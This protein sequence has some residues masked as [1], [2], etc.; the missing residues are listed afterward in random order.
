[1]SGDLS[2]IKNQVKSYKQEGLIMRYQ[3]IR[4]GLIWVSTLITGF[5]LFSCSSKDSNTLKRGKT[6][7][8]NPITTTIPTARQL[9]YKTGTNKVETFK[10]VR[11]AFS[12]DVVNRSKSHLMLAFNLNP[13]VWITPSIVRLSP[14]ARQNVILNFRSVNKS[15]LFS[16]A[17]AVSSSLFT[18]HSYRY[19]AYSD[20]E[21]VMCVPVDT[22]LYSA[23][24]ARTAS[25]LADS[26]T[27]V[28]DKLMPLNTFIYTPGPFYRQ[29]G[30]FARDFLYQLE[31]SGRDIVTAEEVKLGVD[32]LALKQLTANRKVG[33]Y[34]YPKGAIPD[35]IYPDGQFSWGPGLV[36]GDDPAHFHRPSMDAAMCFVTLGWHYGYK[37]GWDAAW[38][39][40]FKEK[41][42]GFADAWNSVPRNTS[43]GLIT[44]WT[45]PGHTGANDIKETHG[46]SV[47]WGFHDSYGFGG[48]DLGTSVLACNAARALADMYEQSGN[49]ES[50][51]VWEKIA[52]DMRD[53]IRAQ[54]NPAG[55]LP[56]GVGV[57]APTMASPDI[58]GYA[59]WS[60]I[61]SDEQADAAS[62][63]FAERYKADKVT[64]G[65]A[66][67]FH[68]SAPFRGA[69]RM[70]RKSDDVSPGRHVWPDMNDGKHWENLA[71]GY[72]AYQDGGY[73][74]YMSLGVAATLWR[75]HPDLA[76]EWVKDAYSD[77]ANAD[78]NTPFERIDGMTP[79]NNRYN[80]SAGSLM[81][82]GMPAV[83]ATVKVGVRK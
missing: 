60:G 70:A 45:T 11:T 73:W 82:M 58:T 42:Q 51:K 56:W 81:G 65:A 37:A 26:R 69:V 75:K 6:K 4:T 57:S 83:V 54:F 48:D 30:I 27:E 64:G 21:T 29:A 67:L 80:A 34:T 28:T 22:A 52:D 78:E 62:D 24:L 72:N 43:T 66:D 7:I 47:M 15:F 12:F 55:Y 38:K 1:M 53:A 41:E 36:F 5:I 40:W 20:G 46:A 8:I 10:A 3:H 16:Y 77:I 50:G 74:Y 49:K 23:L 35:H 79:E 13:E 71:Y 33:M 61:L 19:R 59:V 2:N 14:G 25:I 39:A 68:M 63:W 44:Q 76:M 17:L 31:G 32:F 9:F 18:T